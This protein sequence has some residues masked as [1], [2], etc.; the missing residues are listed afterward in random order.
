MSVIKAE[1]R[2]SNYQF[3][4]T[5]EEIVILLKHEL[6]KV[7]K[8]KHKWVQ[9][10]LYKQTQKFYLNV[11]NARGYVF[12][13][14]PEEKKIK[15]QLFLKAISTGYDFQK[16]LFVYW[17]VQKISFKKQCQL[18]D[19]ICRNIALMGGFLMPKKK[20][21]RL[22]VIDWDAM[23]NV[24][25]LKKLSIF[26]RYIHTKVIT[27]VNDLDNVETAML[28]QLIDD[29]LY[30]AILGNSIYP[31]VL[32]EYKLRE[33]HLEQAIVD[34][35]SLQIP[36]LSYFNIMEYSEGVMENWCNLWDDCV[37]LLKGVKKSDKKRFGNLP[38]MSIEEL[39]EKQEEQITNGEKDETERINLDGRNTVAYIDEYDNST[40]FVN[41][42]Q[43]DTDKDC[44]DETDKTTDLTS[45]TSTTKQ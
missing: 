32:S 16:P 45:S 2:E 14:K 3:E 12:R 20:T 9:E 27:A 42:L 13:K 34:L 44:S 40:M 31:K 6:G 8:R 29:A 30:R 24:Q 21:R 38:N 39:A 36:M 43:S 28:I 25:Y 23:E 15:Q 19:L 17:N 37:K 22:L 10:P 7:S 4:K 33:R 41:K 18:C 35:Y 11:I 5:C 1:R 26:H